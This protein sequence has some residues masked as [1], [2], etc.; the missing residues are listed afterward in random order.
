M[1]HPR[2]VDL[3]CTRLVFWGMVGV[4]MGDD[5]SSEVYRTAMWAQNNNPATS[6]HMVVPPGEA[7]ALLTAPP[8]H[9]PR[10]P[11]PLMLPGHRQSIRGAD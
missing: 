6:R 8:A 7:C 4:D 10:D 2:F 3:F 9:A 1:L 11:P 5:P